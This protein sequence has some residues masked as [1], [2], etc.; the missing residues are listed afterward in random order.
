MSLTPDTS[1]R[2]A[3]RWTILKGKRT[4]SHG[5]SAASCV[6]GTNDPLPLDKVGV[7]ID[8]A[9]HAEHKILLGRLCRDIL[10]LNLQ[11]RRQ[12]NAGKE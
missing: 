2:D 6:V 10:R 5:G 8:L 9:S 11:R 4:G 3:N 1:H 7:G 12:N